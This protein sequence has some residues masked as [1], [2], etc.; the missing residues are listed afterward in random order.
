MRVWCSG[1]DSIPEGDFNSRKAMALSGSMGQ[2]IRSCY[3]NTLECCCRVLL[4][5]RG[6]RPKTLCFLTNTV[7]LNSYKSLTAL[8][9]GGDKTGYTRRFFFGRQPLCGIGVRSSIDLT[10]KPAASSDVIALSRP[11]PGPITRTS[12]SLTPNLIAFSAACCAAHCP[13][14]GVLL[15]LPL[16]P[17]VPALDQ[18]NVSP[19][20][21]VI[22]IVV[23]L[24]V[25]WM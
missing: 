22:V 2:S 15:R 7:L 11:E 1:L 20:V 19:C 6:L 14:N 5:S 17:Q 9:Q 12:Q 25:A 10:F 23:L 18:H 13:A 4:P 3:S 8:P 21:S 24:N 16:K